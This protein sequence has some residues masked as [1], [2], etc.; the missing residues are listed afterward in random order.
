[1]RMHNTYQV[2]DLLAKCLA[3]ATLRKLFVYLYQLRRDSESNYT[4]P[5]TTANVD[6][7][8]AALSEKNTFTKVIYCEFAKLE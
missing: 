3:P 2:N 7:H 5:A 4:K 8:L 6:D 1:M